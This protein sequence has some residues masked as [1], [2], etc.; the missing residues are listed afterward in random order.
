MLTILGDVLLFLEIVLII[1]FITFLVLV[2][3]GTPDDRE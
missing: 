2:C 3:I 1:A